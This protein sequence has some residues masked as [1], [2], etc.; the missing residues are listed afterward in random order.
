M[1]YIF[2]NIY[3]FNRFSGKL[4]IERKIERKAQN[5]KTVLGNK[6]ANRR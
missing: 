6:L 5:L 3:K 1:F 4:P 2:I